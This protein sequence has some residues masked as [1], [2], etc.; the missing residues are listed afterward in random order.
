[1]QTISLPPNLSPDL[2]PLAQALLKRLTIQRSLIS[3]VR[4][5][6]YEPAAHHRLLIAR[7][8]A[9]VAGR[10][11]RLAIFMPPGSAKSTYAR[12]LFPPWYLSSHHGH[13]LLAASHTVSLAERWGRYCRNL[14]DEHSK[15]LDLELAADRAAAGRWTLMNGS[16][17]LAAGAG[18][19]IAGYRAD[20]V[21]IDDPIRGREDADSELIRDKLWDWYRSDV[22]TRLRPG[23]WVVLIQ[24]RW[25]EDDL[26]G[27]LLAEHEAGREHW[28]V[29]SLPAEAEENDAL[30]REPGA[31]LWDDDPTYSYG[32][33]LRREKETQTPR[34]WSALYQQ[35]P[36]PDTGDYF[37]ESWLL[38]YKTAPDRAT[39]NTYGASDYA[40]TSN[41]GDYTVHVV[42][43]IDPKG[44]LWLL[45]M[46]RKQAASD[47]WIETLCDLIRKWKPIGWAEE[48]IQ[49]T[50]GIG[51]HLERR[52]RERGAYTAREQFPTRGDKAARAQSIRGRMALKGLHV[53]TS[54]PWYSDFRSE[55]LHFPAGKHDD[56]VDALGLVGQLLDR[57]ADGRKPKGAGEYNYETFKDSAYKSPN[58]GYSD[59]QQSSVKLL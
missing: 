49:I 25:H 16:E 44:D 53:P 22:A 4:Y 8:E 36:T 30:S 39:L 10:I 5:C 27:R 55:L 34:N 18:G 24:T 9:V 7:L 21:L 3:W 59:Y 46:W 14:I 13:N 32:E 20:G 28:E 37:Q 47:Q 56:I 31:W 19:A 54:A 33:L 17:Y 23:G 41:G 2:L 11:K 52:Q 48:K 26:A 6:G 1:M 43:G 58:D 45:D 51:P 50:S 40:V 15:V 29:I 35:R 57:M 12:R 42:V 38:P